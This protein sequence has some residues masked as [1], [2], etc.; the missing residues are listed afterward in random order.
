MNCLHKVV[1]HLGYLHPTKCCY[2]CYQ[3]ELDVVVD[4]ENELRMAH[5]AAYICVWKRTNATLRYRSKMFERINDKLKK[6]WERQIV[7]NELE[8]VERDRKK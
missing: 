8:V 4:M 3:C 2:G 5:L 7:K 6:A 1:G